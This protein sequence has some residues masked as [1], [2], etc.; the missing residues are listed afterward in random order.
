MQS[1]HERSS[2]GGVEMA[3]KILNRITRFHLL[4]PRRRGLPTDHQIKRLDS[5]RS[6]WRRPVRH[7]PEYAILR[8]RLHGPL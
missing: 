2:V 8:L 1:Y 3:A 4:G 5:G 7:Q 6:R